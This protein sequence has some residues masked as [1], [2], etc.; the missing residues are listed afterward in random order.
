MN[1]ENPEYKMG[2]PQKSQ[3]LSYDSQKQMKNRDFQSYVNY[4]LPEEFDYES[5]Y[6]PARSR[7]QSIAPTY[8]SSQ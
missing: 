5:K 1:G 2:I 8:N 3:T 6:N 4:H 7:N